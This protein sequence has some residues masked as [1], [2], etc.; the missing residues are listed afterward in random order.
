MTKNFLPYSEHQ[1]QEVLPVKLISK[2][3]EIR[4]TKT[5][6]KG[7]GDDLVCFEI[8]KT[9]ETYEINTNYLIGYDWVNK[10]TV[11]E[12]KPKIENIDF[13]KMLFS[14]L[15]HPE[16][17]K[18]IDELF[19]VK[20]EEEAIEIEQKK[21]LLTPFL[22]I[23][24]LALLKNIVKKGLKK[25]YYKKNQNLNSKVKGKVLVGKTIKQNILQNKSL[26]THCTFEEFGF[27][28][29][30]NRLLKKALTFV[31]RYLPTYAKIIDQKE[32]QNTFNYIN[33]AFQFVSDEININEVKFG[34]TNAF[35]VEYGKALNLAKQILKRFGYTISNTEKQNIKTPPFWIDMTKLFELYVLGLLKDRFFNEVKFQFKNYGNELD[36]LLNSSDYK[37]VVDAKYK[38]NYCDGYE[39]EDI[40]QVSGYARLKKVYKDLGIERGQVIDCLIIYPDQ[41][42]GVNDL[43][44]KNLRE[45]EIPNYFD[46]FKLGVKLPLIGK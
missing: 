10:D 31:Q 6:K 15:K 34:K 37:M 28:N 40:R 17:T 35:Y 13:V 18:E 36:Y 32:L 29:I 3:R 26:Y 44:R 45:K 2:L 16:V 38:P 12:V 21:D 22:V 19:I 42:N 30:E 11:I 4:Y 46:V 25:S 14:S 20:W 9:D 8:Q 43:K 39:N 5:F 1:K 41:E 33:P 23:E 24:F 27:D 7:K